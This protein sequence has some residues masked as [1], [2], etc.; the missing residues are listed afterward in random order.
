M[1]VF[2]WIGRRVPAGP[3]SSAVFVYVYGLCKV[4]YISVHRCRSWLPCVTFR[5]VFLF[6]FSVFEVF[7]VGLLCIKIFHRCKK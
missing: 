3:G 5:V 7:Q 6:L 4:L 1:N 2:G